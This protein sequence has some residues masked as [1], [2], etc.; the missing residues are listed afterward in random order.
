[1][2]YK[3]KSVQVAIAVAVIV[4]IFAVVFIPDQIQEETIKKPV[5]PS[6]LNISFNNK[7]GGIDLCWTDNS[8]NEKGFKVYRRI[9]DSQPSY[10]LVKVLP[11]D[12]TYYHDPLRTRREQTYDYQ[13]C[14]YNMLGNSEMISISVTKR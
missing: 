9:Q 12:S 1:M 10:H 14:S 2:W 11:P 5:E 13:V 7:R 3:K 8:S 4:G 6:N